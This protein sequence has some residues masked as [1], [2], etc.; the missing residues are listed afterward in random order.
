MLGMISAPQVTGLMRSAV[1][2]SPG[3][4]LEIIAGAVPVPAPGQVVLKVGRCGICGTDL[5]MTEPGSTLLSPGAVI[6]HEIS[7]EVVEVG[8]GVTLVKVGDRVAALPI[9]GCGRCNS[10]RRGE[11]VW[12]A[13]G[14]QFLA[15]G[16]AQY[17]IA[18]EASCLKLPANL[19]FAD[20]ALVEPLAVALH[21]V[22]MV[23]TLKDLS[24]LV[25]G[26]GPIG[27]SVVFWA[28]RMG[29]RHIGVV[30]GNAA[31][32]EMAMAMGA[33]FSS[34]PGE[35]TDQPELEAPEIVVECVGRPGLLRA[36]IEAVRPRGTVISLG[37]CIQPDEIV[38]SEAGRRE[39]T[40]VFPILYSLEEYQITL[41]TL[42]EG[43]VEPRVMVTDTVGFSRLPSIFEEL[44]GR[45]P[46]CK[47]MIDPW[48]EAWSGDEVRS[49]PAASSNENSSAQDG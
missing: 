35:T 20:G 23:P 13:N 36:A 37:Y 41:D 49:L 34:L 44:R 48:A 39:V 9:I 47:V 12:C 18:G 7:G 45:S 43:S 21:G 1:F 8:P 40:L 16:Y 46:H 15:G 2:T 28:R 38:T 30:E 19:S 26:A 25:L 4:P 33:S 29:A 31:R 10:C 27:L 17:A 6:G 24:V 11:P 42:A 14:R 32:V 22:R 3:R 5:H